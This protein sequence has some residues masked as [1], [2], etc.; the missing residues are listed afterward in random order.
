M[1]KTIELQVGVKAFV[2]LS[3]PSSRPRGN[4]EGK[5]LMLRRAEPYPDETEPRWDIVGGRITPGEPIRPALARE[6]KEETG[7]ILT[8]VDHVLYAQDI[9]RVKGR[10]VV[11]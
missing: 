3:A 11:R 10:H 6:I 9:L 8:S 1:G 5:F 4:G 7:L 2:R